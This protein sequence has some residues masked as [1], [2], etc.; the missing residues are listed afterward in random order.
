MKLID[1]GF[2][3]IEQKVPIIKLDKDKYIFNSELIANAKKQI[4]KAGRICYKSEDKITEDSYKEFFKM[5]RNKG[6]LS[7][8]EHGT[9]YFRIILG[10]PM[11]DDHYLWKAQVIQLFKRNPYS[12]VVQI[13]EPS[14]VDDKPVGQVEC[15]YITTN[16][17]VVEEICNIKSNN[18]IEEIS[19][20]TL[21][22]YLSAPTEH[23]IKRYSVKFTCSRAISHELV[24][25]RVFSFSQESQRYCNYSKGKYGMEITFIKPEY[26][27]N[28]PKFEQ[29]LNV[30]EH[31]YFYLL[32]IGAL[33][34]EAREV[35]P[36]STKTEI[37]M[38]GF[39]DDWKQFFRLRTSKAA[40]SEMRRLIIPLQKEFKKLGYV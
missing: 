14:Y 3:I 4:E 11:Y 20:K 37:I 34:Q 28:N 10:T 1:P 19:E 5:I 40:H 7:V 25:H 18:L 24:R 15:F 21:F 39:E 17:R 6:H 12:R 35:L 22:E 27:D 9:L 2:E 32:S 23:H 31:S 30:T 29:A 33:P 38:T 26:F 8:F 13:Q 36:N 16:Y